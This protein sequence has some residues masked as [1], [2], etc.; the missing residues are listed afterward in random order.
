MMGQNAGDNPCSHQSQDLRFRYRSMQ[1]S[2]VLKYL[3]RA[4]HKQDAKTGGH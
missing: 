1:T 3:K 4:E 2:S